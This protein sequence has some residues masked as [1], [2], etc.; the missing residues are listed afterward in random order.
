MRTGVSDFWG[1]SLWKVIHSMA[2]NSITLK[3][4][5][6]FKHFM[7]SL[8]GSLPCDFCS[9]N[10][11]MNLKILN[12]ND[13]LDNVE[14]LL[15]WSYKLHQLVNIETN[16]QTPEWEHVK[17]LFLNNSID[18]YNLRLN[19]I[20]TLHYDLVRIGTIKDDFNFYHCLLYCFS[21]TYRSVE[22]QDKLIIV[23]KL[24]QHISNDKSPNMSGIE[25]ITTAFDIDIYILLDQNN[26]K[27]FK[28]LYT[29]SKSIVLYLHFKSYWDV[30]GRRMSLNSNQIQVVFQSNDSLFS[31]LHFLSV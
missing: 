7:Y 9:Y 5:L 11:T 2:A 4:R 17:F 18:L 16:K 29:R 6:L 8:I 1:P 12:I 20:Q 26:V 19:E 10:L 22:T 3:K 27:V 30:I 23:K 13:Y 31:L 15:F 28:G 25:Y 14:N 24:Y 21:P